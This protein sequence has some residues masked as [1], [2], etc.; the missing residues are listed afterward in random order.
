MD[1]PRLKRRKAFT[2]YISKAPYLEMRERVAL[3]KFYRGDDSTV[4]AVLMID[5]DDD[6]KQAMVCSLLD[7][8]TRGSS[9]E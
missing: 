9:P 4:E 1:S 5:D 8:A 3:I 2:S 7:D 6:M